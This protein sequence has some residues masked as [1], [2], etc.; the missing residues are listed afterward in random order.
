MTEKQEPV[1]VDRWEVRQAIATTPGGQS[2]VLVAG[3]VAD[4][5]VVVVP[6]TPD[7]AR[8]AAETMLRY[9]NEIDARQ[10]PN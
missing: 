2:Y 9:A 5:D 1:L 6:F 10:R 8:V 3:I 4:V 7:Q